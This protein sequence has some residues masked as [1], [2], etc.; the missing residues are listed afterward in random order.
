MENVVLKVNK[1]V[2]KIENGFTILGSESTENKQSSIVI[3]NNIV[4][5]K[6]AIIWKNC[7][8]IKIMDLCT[9][10]GTKVGNIQLHPMEWYE[11]K[12]DSLIRFGFMEAKLEIDKIEDNNP[13]DEIENSPVHGFVSRFQGS[14]LK[15]SSNI[16]NTSATEFIVPATQDQESF[17][18]TQ[19][20]FGHYRKS[21]NKSKTPDTSVYIPETQQTQRVSEEFFMLTETQD[22]NHH[23]MESQN[24][25]ADIDFESSPKSK[26]RSVKINLASTFSELV[27]GDDD[28]LSQLDLAEAPKTC[29]DTKVASTNQKS[30]SVTPEIE[31][32][33]AKS[34]SC[35]PEIHLPETPEKLS[36]NVENQDLIATQKFDSGLT[37]TQD[38]SMDSDVD[39]TEIFAVNNE[40]DK[41]M[42]MRQDLIATQKFTASEPEA[43]KRNSITDIDATQKFIV[44]PIEGENERQDEIATQA[45]NFEQSVKREDPMPSTSRFNP[46]DCA[47][48]MLTVPDFKMPFTRKQAKQEFENQPKSRKSAEELR[49]EMSCYDTETQAMVLDDDAEFCR[50]VQNNP[51]FDMAT[52]PLLLDQ[53]QIPTNNVQI[54]DKENDTNNRNACITVH[55]KRIDIL[56]T[57][58]P[59]LYQDNHFSSGSSSGEEDLD[60]DFCEM[61]TFCVVDQSLPKSKKGRKKSKSKKKVLATRPRN[62]INLPSDGSDDERSNCNP[63]VEMI[64]S[65]IPSSSGTFSNIPIVRPKP[66]IVE[67]SNEIEELELK[68]VHPNEKTPPRLTSILSQD[69][70]QTPEL[71]ADFPNTEEIDDMDFDEINRSQNK[72]VS[73]S[74]AVFNEISDDEEREEKKK[75]QIKIEEKKTKLNNVR[76]LKFESEAIGGIEEEAPL[77]PVRKSSR[78]KTEPAKMREAVVRV[79]KFDAETKKKED[80]PKQSKSV[81]RQID[82]DSEEEQRKTLKTSRTTRKKVERKEEKEEPESSR[83]SQRSK[84]TSQAKEERNF[85]GFSDADISDSE[86]RYTR[87]HMV[88]ES[89][90]NKTKDAK[91]SPSREH[92]KGNKRRGS[93]GEDEGRSKSTR[94]AKSGAS[95][96]LKPYKI[97]FSNTQN[98]E[99]LL[100]VTTRL[101]AVIVEDIKEAD[102]LIVGKF[103]LTTKVLAAIGKGIPMLTPAWILDTQKNGVLPNASKY[104]NCDKDHEKRFKYSLQTILNNSFKKRPFKGYNIIVTSL[105]DPKPDDLKKIIECADAKYY[106]RNSSTLPKSKDNLFVVT[107]SKNQD[108]EQCKSLKKKYGNDLV[109][110]NEN[111]FIMDCILKQKLDYSGKLSI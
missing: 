24:L 111:H 89:S 40:E 35:T 94:S 104:L 98:T 106:S 108:K 81:K 91:N 66:T 67:N 43:K 34:R 78:Q 19:M 7:S 82:S 95:K 17:T 49:K 58:T 4:S 64:L 73:D 109:F 77:E 36:E 16:S 41:N 47:T 76:F 25:L 26:E 11:I 15:S 45:F 55:S 75:I 101:G 1:T 90:K 105:T 100:K 30:R 74:E 93:D 87:R 97:A 52:Q 68:A 6:H 5:K 46:Y 80:K 63:E 62:V 9:D 48:Q 84:T 99:S 31:C 102:I 3:K 86:R 54:H 37:A 70:L 10:A 69:D 44:E 57:P 21:L 18:E 8:T 110:L 12:S 28:E 20:A 13:V 56:R 61:S 14:R 22:T 23:A 2:H 79:K 42:S 65:K 53:I 107:S 33:Q 71:L 32:N 83:R 60:P 29:S 50:P 72:T 103:S 96:L 38:K 59:E 27:D 51:L 88:R 85:A 92:F 39:A